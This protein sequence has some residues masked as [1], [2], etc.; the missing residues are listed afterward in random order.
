[1][2]VGALWLAALVLLPPLAPG[3]QI[4]ASGDWTGSI[5]PGAGDAIELTLTLEAGP[6]GVWT[7]TVAAPALGDAPVA[8]RGITVSGGEVRFAA[9]SLPGSPEFVGRL[10]DDGLEISGSVV[11]DP[12]A[13]PP[14][15]DI[16]LIEIEASGSTWNLGE[17]V[18]ITDRDGYDNQPQFLADAQALL[19]T[20]IRDGQADI[21]RYD[22]AGRRSV[23]VT[24]TVESEYS[25]TPLPS[26]DGFST[27]RVEDNGTQRLWSFD[28]DGR[29][30][31][32]VLRE[33]RPVGYHGW[34]DEHRLGIF[35]LGT[36]PTLQIADVES[37]TARLVADGIGRA[38]HLTPDGAAVSFVHKASED[39]WRIDRIELQSGD[40]RT[41]IAT[42]P[43]SEDFI[44]TPDGRIL[45]AEGAR[46]FACSP[47]DEAPSWR[48]IADLGGHGIGTLT[49]L[50]VS[51]DTAWLAVVGERPRAA[52]ATARVESPF[53]LRRAR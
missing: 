11:Q 1:M 28:F 20:S 14:A 43:G 24:D 34:L 21:Y 53:L 48:Q 30:P 16:H 9:V 15:T 3:Q 38:I 45:M 5:R 8:L 17:P 41:L 33:I 25:P 49:R 2:R 32:L 10:S 7:G 27:V 40:R 18:N 44:W 37:Q 52:A 19:Y 36:P 42:R 39:D 13:P 29:N 46:L 6:D 4:G 47:A 22:L 50:A 26:G 51:S 35:V 12:P 23:R 31:M